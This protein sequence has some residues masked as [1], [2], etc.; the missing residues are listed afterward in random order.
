MREEVTVDAWGVLVL[1]LGVGAVSGVL[2]IGG[3]LLMIPG[4]IYVFGFSQQKAQG[5]TLAALVPP[6]GLLAAIQYYRQGF[7]DPW[8]ALWLAIGFAVGAF[9]S[10]GFIEDINAAV[11]TQL[12]AM[13]LLFLG[14]RMLLS[15]DRLVQ[16]FAGALI[17]WLFAWALFL[18]CRHWGKRFAVRPRL[19]V[20]LDE[21][22][23]TRPVDNDFQI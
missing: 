10:A 15:S 4:L 13:L 1:G 23:K 22:A 18:V 11:L 3:G 21:S 5:T 8:A 7:V 14:V 19:E 9:I 16:A 12:F 20:R 6:V 2:G 17:A